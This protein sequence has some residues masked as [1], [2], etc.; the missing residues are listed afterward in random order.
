MQCR[1]SR[2]G[3]EAG[4]LPLGPSAPSAPGPGPPLLQ[5]YRRASSWC[6]IQVSMPPSSFTSLRELRAK[7][8]S[9]RTHTGQHRKG[10][11]DNRRL[12]SWV[13]PE[14][15]TIPT[16][17]TNKYVQKRKPHLHLGNKG[18]EGNISVIVGDFSGLTYTFL[19]FVPS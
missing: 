9:R 17:C 3:A 18:L 4:L 13:R 2:G 19:Y 8:V 7:P 10:D 5:A 6:S 16:L 15:S 1:H 12:R 14:S 11:A